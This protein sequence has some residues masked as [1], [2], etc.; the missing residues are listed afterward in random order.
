MVLHKITLPSQTVNFGNHAVNIF[1]ET[2]EAFNFAREIAELKTLQGNSQPFFVMDV[3]R[4]SMLLDEWFNCLPRVQPY[5]A[6]NC[7]SDPVLLRL[8]ANHP[9]V[10][11]HC[12]TRENLDFVTEIVR[13]ERILY[14]N[15]CWT[16]GAL[17]YAHQAGVQT[18]AF[19]SSQS[20]DR[21]LGAC[22]DAE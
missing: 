11:F 22:P 21:I 5:Y 6:V 2:R 9:S 3:D 15:P 10:G 17:R 7:N 12:I 16:R 20:L 18:L 14:A 4:I 1:P 13:P 19:D 8:L